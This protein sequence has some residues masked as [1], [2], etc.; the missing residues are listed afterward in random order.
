MLATLKVFAQTESCFLFCLNVINADGRTEPDGG[1]PDRPQQ[2]PLHHAGA[3]GGPAGKKPTQGSAHGSSGRAPALQEVRM[4]IE[5]TLKSLTR[6]LK[7][8]YKVSCAS[9]NK[10]HIYCINSWI[11][12]QYM[13]CAV[14]FCHKLNHPWWK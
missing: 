4:H 14:G 1:G 9:V 12:V 7:L 5:F 3:E 13:L 11:S 8:V 6:R 2:T 10:L